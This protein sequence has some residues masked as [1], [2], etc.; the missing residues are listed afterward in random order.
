MSH[1]KA[2]LGILCHEKS[3]KVVLAVCGKT[4]KL[5]HCV[6]LELGRSLMISIAL[7]R[8]ALM[9]RPFYAATSLGMRIRL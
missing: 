5:G 6:G 7:R 8:D 4:G 1:R 9:G 2:D 3:T